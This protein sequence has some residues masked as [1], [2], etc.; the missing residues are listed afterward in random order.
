M[1]TAIYSVVVL[2]LLSSAQSGP[3]GTRGRRPEETR[4]A[5]SLSAVSVPG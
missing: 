3:Q 2:L 1:Y 4:T 5:T